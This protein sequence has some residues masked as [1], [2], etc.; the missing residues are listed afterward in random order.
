MR[1]NVID[2]PGFS[3]PV[4]GNVYA[5]GGGYGR[6]AGHAMVLMAITRN[7]AALMLIIDKEGEPVGVTSYGMH[8]IEERVPIAFVRG[9]D[10]MSFMMEPI[11]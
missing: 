10:E 9:F 1:I 11:R 6:R 2:L 5:I 8:A 4:V 7:Q 3:Q